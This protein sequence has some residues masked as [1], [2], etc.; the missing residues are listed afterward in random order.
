MQSTMP[1]KETGVREYLVRNLSAQLRS[2][3][4]HANSVTAST[5]PQ[6]FLRQA[7]LFVPLPSGG[8]QPG[9]R[10]RGSPRAEELR[11]GSREQHAEEGS[12]PRGQSSSQA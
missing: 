11:P 1:Q 12:V 3:E 9:L 7:V 8:V 2:A 10:P 5:E 6:A 4:K